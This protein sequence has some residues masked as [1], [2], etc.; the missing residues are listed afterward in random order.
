[1]ASYTSLSKKSSFIFNY[2][3]M[4]YLF[5]ILTYFDKCTMVANLA[6]QIG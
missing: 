2:F 3:S 4:L 1:M 5:D 6:L